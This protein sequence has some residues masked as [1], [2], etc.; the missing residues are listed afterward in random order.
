MSIDKYFEDIDIERFGLVENEW[1][2]LVEDY[3]LYKTI[4]GRIRQLSGDERLISNKDTSMT[5]HRLYTKELD[6]LVTD[7]VKYKDKWYN[8]V[9]VNNVMNFDRIV[10]IDLRLIE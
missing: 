9:T 10:Q 8:I 7:R 4:Q 2:D 3:S 5:T 1:G 6:I